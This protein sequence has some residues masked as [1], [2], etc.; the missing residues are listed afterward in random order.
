MAQL[1]G[2][3][4]STPLAG[5]LPGTDHCRPTVQLLLYFPM[6]E[7]FCLLRESHADCAATRN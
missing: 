3:Q 6:E 2:R 1:D 7:T 4:A 5:I